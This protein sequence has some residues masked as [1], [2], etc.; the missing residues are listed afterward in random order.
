MHP[1]TSDV[2]REEISSTP[3]YQ[4]MERL[5]RKI[6]RADLTIRAQAAGHGPGRL[7]EVA[8]AEP[9]LILDRTSYDENR[10]SA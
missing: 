6:A 1:I 7:L 2:T 3:I 4:I 9:V 5:G 10:R 8:A